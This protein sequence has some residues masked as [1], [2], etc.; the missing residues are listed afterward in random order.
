MARKFSE[1]RIY[2]QPQTEVRQAVERAL[3]ELGLTIKPGGTE[4]EITASR[5]INPLSWG[6]RITVT[7]ATFPGGGTQVITESK[8]SLG[9][10]FVDWGRNQANVEAIYQA[11][12]PVVGPGERADLPN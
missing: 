3:V 5:G 2:E 8:L 9:I 6:E 11:M 12:E 4:W 10:A 1:R 7:M